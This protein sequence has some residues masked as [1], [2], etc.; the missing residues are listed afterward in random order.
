MRESTFATSFK[1]AR[2]QHLFWRT[3]LQHARFGGV[4]KDALLIFDESLDAQVNK[5]VRVSQSE[6]QILKGVD[7][8]PCL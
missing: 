5:P 3:D 8:Y 6:D 7:S 2:H 1:F 4:A